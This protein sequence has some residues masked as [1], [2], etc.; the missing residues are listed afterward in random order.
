M[1]KFNKDAFKCECSNW[2]R[3]VWVGEE[4]KFQEPHHPICPFHEKDK[5]ATSKL[6]IRHLLWAMREWASDE[7]GVHPSA[8]RAY[9]RAAKFV[10]EDELGAA[11]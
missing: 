1:P 5:L 4:M 3:E 8:T 10:G 6:I 9:D 11:R 7:D 2:G